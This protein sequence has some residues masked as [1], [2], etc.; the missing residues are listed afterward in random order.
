[1]AMATTTK[2]AYKLIQGSAEELLLAMSTDS[3]YKKEKLSHGKELELTLAQMLAAKN[4]SS[5][6]KK[7]NVLEVVDVRKE[8]PEPDELSA[9]CIH[10]CKAM[11]E[12]IKALQVLA[13]QVMAV[14]RARKAVTCPAAKKKRVK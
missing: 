10:M 8:F 12:K 4:G 11:D 7:F 14:V 9:K 1:M 13:R 6:F 2:T 5:F 3:D